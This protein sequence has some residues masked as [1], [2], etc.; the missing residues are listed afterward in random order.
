MDEMRAVLRHRDF[1]MLWT[2]MTASLLGDGIFY[3]AL[4]WQA[5][6][7]SN[8]PS[9]LSMIGVAM[10]VPHVVFLLAGGVVSDRFDRR[11]VVVVTH[12]I[13]FVISAVLAVLMIAGAAN[14]LHVMATMF[15]LQ[16][17]WTLAKPSSSAMLP[18]LM[19]R[20]QLSEAVG[21]NTL[22]FMIAQLAYVLNL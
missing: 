15:L 17:S 2:G 21:L 11:L 19:P 9:A 4:A 5:Y 3:V 6:E 13:S 16:T 8:T 20:A 14:E 18:E 22:Q 10:T 1:R 12:V 7:L